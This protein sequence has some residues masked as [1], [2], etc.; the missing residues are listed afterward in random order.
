MLVC[1]LR[2]GNVTKGQYV[3]TGV[4]ASTR[5]NGVSKK[6]QGRKV[7]SF[8]Q[9]NREPPRIQYRFFAHCSTG[10]LLDSTIMALSDYR[11]SRGRGYQY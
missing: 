6:R 9:P 11:N 5:V 7:V 10:I 3:M 2:S 8:V 4:N 1:C